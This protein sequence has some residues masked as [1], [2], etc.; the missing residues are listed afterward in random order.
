MKGERDAYRPARL[1]KIGKRGQK[2]LRLWD[3]RPCYPKKK[4]DGGREKTGLE[5]A[6]RAKKKS[7]LKQAV[8]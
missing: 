3:V 1:R 4:K 5:K 7:A 6:E 2:L 8:L